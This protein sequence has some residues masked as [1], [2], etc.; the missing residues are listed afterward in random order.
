MKNTT[1]VSADIKPTVNAN[2]ENWTKQTEWHGNPSLGYDCYCKLFRNPNNGKLVP[3]YVYGN[4]ESLQLSYVVSAG[5]TS[6]YSYGGCFYPE[7]LTW[8]ETMQ[9]IDET[10]KNGRI[11]N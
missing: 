7:K 11:F 2:A 1:S 3:I 10:Y 5:K 4:S 9:R 8:A 6:D